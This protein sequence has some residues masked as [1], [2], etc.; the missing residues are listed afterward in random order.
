MV[1]I[2]SRV[3]FCAASAWASCSRVMSPSAISRSPNRAM[4]RSGVG[5]GDRSGPTAGSAGT[6]STS[7]AFDAATP[8]E[9]RTPDSTARAETTRISLS[10]SPSLVYVSFSVSRAP[11]SAGFAS[12]IISH[13]RADSRS[14]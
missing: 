3:P 8:T 5:P 4:R 10:R 2:L 1:P 11:V 6:S 9:A 14:E 12:T 13:R 7:S